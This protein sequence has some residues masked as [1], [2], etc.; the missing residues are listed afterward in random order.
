MINKNRQT[1]KKYEVGLNKKSDLRKQMQ[2]A[3]CGLIVVRR[4]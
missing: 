4:L 2:N 3:V 1:D